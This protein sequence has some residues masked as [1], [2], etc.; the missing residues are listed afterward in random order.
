MLISNV[1]E[2]YSD[3]KNATAQSSFSCQKMALNTE[4]THVGGKRIIG[5]ERVICITVCRLLT[6]KTS[7]DHKHKEIV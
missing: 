6:C 1:T 2:D 5:M 4:K 3:K 7:V